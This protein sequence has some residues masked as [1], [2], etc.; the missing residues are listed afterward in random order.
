MR[1]IYIVNATQ[2]VASETHP[3]GVYSVVSGFPKT[4]DSRNYN[5]TAEN[6]DGDA[7]KALRIAKSEYSAQESAFLASDSRAMWTVTLTMAD[8][9]QIASEC[10]GAFPN[11]TTEP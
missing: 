1:N 10:F 7:N 9:R 11:V 4:F 3:E 8:G 2:V 6:L 5:A